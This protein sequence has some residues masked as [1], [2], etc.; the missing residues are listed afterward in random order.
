ME[1]WPRRGSRRLGPGL[2]LTAPALILV[3]GCDAPA[4][5]PAPPPLTAA[6]SEHP[7]CGVARG[8]A[9]AR[10]GA[11]ERQAEA[12][13]A[14]YAFAPEVGLAVWRS[15]SEAADCRR[16]ADDAQAA[17]HIEVLAATWRARL[18]HDLRSGQLRLRRAL[19]ASESAAA[20][21]QARHLLSLLPATDDGY[22]RWLL[23]IREAG[24][25]PSP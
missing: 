22:R 20:A 8:A 23:Q 1:R 5:A 10:A 24:A 19:A 16:L 14:R 13:R 17:R 25:E 9:A 6:L 12:Q 21:R 2:T 18:E 3:L 4:G 11:L 15:W 7:P